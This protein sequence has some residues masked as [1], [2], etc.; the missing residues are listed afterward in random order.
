MSIRPA[1]AS[2]LFPSTRS[3]T[4]PRRGWLYPNSA[5]SLFLPQNHHHNQTWVTCPPKSRELLTRSHRQTAG[6]HPRRGKCSVAA[7]LCLLWGGCS[8]QKESVWGVR[9]MRTSM[10][11]WNCRGREALFLR[12][13]S[14]VCFTWHDDGISLFDIA[15]KGKKR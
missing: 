1:A 9:S 13:T 8:S 15:R 6:G 7:L 14:V 3:R 4:E 11:G 5:F 12:A 2:L 10:V